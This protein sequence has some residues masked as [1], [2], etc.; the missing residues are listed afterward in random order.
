MKRKNDK[1]PVFEV[2]TNST[3]AFYPLIIR[4]PVTSLVSMKIILSRNK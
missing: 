4:E 1:F 2:I 3:V